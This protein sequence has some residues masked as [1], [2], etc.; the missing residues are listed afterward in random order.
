MVSTAL[1]GT[2]IETHVD[3]RTEVMAHPEYLFRSLANVVRNAIRYAGECGPIE[4]SALAKDGMVLISVADQG[5]GIPEA[6][7]EAVFKP[8]YRPEDARQRETGGVGLGLAIVRT[9]IEA[10][11]G[12]VHCHNRP[13]KGLEVEM[14]LPAPNP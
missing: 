10:C 13:P 3:E 6:E 5:P 2:R 4:I 14:R 7:L 9:C 12:T 11:G 8:F 1:L